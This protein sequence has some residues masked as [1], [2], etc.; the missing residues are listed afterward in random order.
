M[1][2]LVGY[3][4]CVYLVLKGLE[5]LVTA[6]AG[7]EEKNVH[8]LNLLLALL[9]LAGAIGAAYLFVGWFTAQGNA[10]PN[11]PRLP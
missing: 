10:M 6:L 8:N 3:L 4:G 9:A 1:L 5:I 11:F 2:Q 7:R